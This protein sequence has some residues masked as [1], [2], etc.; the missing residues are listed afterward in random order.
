MI[1]RIVQEQ[2]L[3]LQNQNLK[4][5]DLKDEMEIEK[6]KVKNLEEKMAFLEAPLNKILEQKK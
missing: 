2:Q 6:S 5:K 1:R 4:V 3:T